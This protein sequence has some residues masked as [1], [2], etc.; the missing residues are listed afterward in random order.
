MAKQIEGVYEKILECAKNEFL[1]NGYNDASLRTIAANAD[2][3]TQSIYVR[4]HNKEG[5]FTAIVEP[6]INNQ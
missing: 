6:V 2:T 3:S 5:L 4:F 1:K